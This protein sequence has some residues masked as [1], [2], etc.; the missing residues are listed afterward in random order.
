MYGL[1]SLQLNQDQRERLNT[2]H[3]KGLRQ[4]LNIPTTFGQMMKGQKPT[5]DTDRIYKLINSKLNA[6]EERRM[7]GVLCNFN[8]RPSYFCF[9]ENRII[10]E[11]C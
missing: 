11:L 10:N 1:E 9:E 7:E 4:I 6:L 3:L 5:W 8:I 2:I